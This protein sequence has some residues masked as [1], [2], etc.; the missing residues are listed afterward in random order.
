[1]RSHCNAPIPPST[2]SHTATWPPG[3]AVL[4]VYG[5]SIFTQLSYHLDVLSSPDYIGVKI[6]IEVDIDG[7]NWSEYQSWW[8]ALTFA[9]WTSLCSAVSAACLSRSAELF[10]CNLT[11]LSCEPKLSPTGQ[12]T[13]KHNGLYLLLSAP[14]TV[15]SAVRRSLLCW[16]LRLSLSLLLF[17]DCITCGNIALRKNR[18]K[19]IY[20]I[21]TYHRQTIFLFHQKCGARSRSP[22]LLLV[23]CRTLWGEPERVN[24]QSM[25]RFHAHDHYQMWLSIK[26]QARIYETKMHNCNT[27]SGS[28]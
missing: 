6:L 21:W 5:Y 23:E 25:E 26:P 20:G 3:C 14:L 18:A 2:L 8:A 15:P 10:L 27:E 28:S 24:V 22:Q 17:S 11:Y 19:C 9:S 16:F 7:V 13:A 4:Y 12:Q 1:M